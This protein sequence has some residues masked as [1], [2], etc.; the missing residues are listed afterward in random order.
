MLC[1]DFLFIG[2]AVA[3]RG[4]QVLS[5]GEPSNTASLDLFLPSHKMGK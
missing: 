4:G 2:L 5:P 1:F 3:V